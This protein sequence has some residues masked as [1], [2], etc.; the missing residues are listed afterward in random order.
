MKVSTVTDPLLH[1]RCV[2]NLYILY[3]SLAL[4]NS[5]VSLLYISQYFL[6]S[7]VLTQG[8]RFTDNSANVRTFAAGG[9]HLLRQPCNPQQENEGRSRAMLK[10][11]TAKAERRV[12][13]M[14]FTLSN[15][16]EKRRHSH[17]PRRT[18]TVMCRE[19][20][21]RK[22]NFPRDLYWTGN[23]PVSMGQD[24]PFYRCRTWQWTGREAPARPVP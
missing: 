12:H 9:A 22:L 14:L 4:T 6:S 10:D 23:F 20:L 2:N 18:W 15:R 24:R 17:G 16:S 3:T 11:E 19:N 1:P 8:P 5:S 21:T 13:I 7:T